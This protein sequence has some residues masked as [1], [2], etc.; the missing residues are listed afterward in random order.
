[1][2]EAPSNHLAEVVEDTVFIGLL[3]VNE[4]YLTLLERDGV[5]NPTDGIPAFSAMF[6]AIETI[7]CK[8]LIVSRGGNHQVSRIKIF[9]VFDRS[10]QEQITLR[11]KVEVYERLRVR[12]ATARL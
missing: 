9:G 8:Y 6:S 1:V 4:D 7:S 3:V 5:E 12:L 11:M 10:Y 2:S